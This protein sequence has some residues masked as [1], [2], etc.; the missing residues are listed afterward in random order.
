MYSKKMVTIS[1]MCSK[2]ESVRPIVAEKIEKSVEL[3]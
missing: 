2:P 1:G 3:V